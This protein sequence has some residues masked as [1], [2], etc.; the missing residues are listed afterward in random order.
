MGHLLVLNILWIS[1]LFSSS[2]YRISF[3]NQ[4]MN[5]LKKY[6]LEW[7][8]HSWNALVILNIR[9]CKINH[10]KYNLKIKKIKKKCQTYSNKYTSLNVPNICFLLLDLISISVQFSIYINTAIINAPFHWVFSG[11]L[12]EYIFVKS[13]WVLF[14][15]LQD[16]IFFIKLC[17]NG[18]TEKASFHYEFTDLCIKSLPHCSN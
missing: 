6:I 5:L 16:Q 9:Q 8:Q 4:F 7:S 10:W 13:H 3:V 1:I 17:H 2:D 18:Y 12:C 11:V 15:D 14:D